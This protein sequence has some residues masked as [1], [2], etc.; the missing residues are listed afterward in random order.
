MGFGINICGKNGEKKFDVI[1]KKFDGTV[2]KT[3]KNV[4]YREI[5]S[6]LDIQGEHVQNNC[7]R[8]TDYYEW[9]KLALRGKTQK[10]KDLLTK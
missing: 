5:F 8:S 1:I 10:A 7:Y 9:Y 3:I 6:R 4:S 2:I